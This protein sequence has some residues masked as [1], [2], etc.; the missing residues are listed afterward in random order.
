MS[1]REVKRNGRGQIIS[2]EIIGATDSAVDSQT[3]GEVDLDNDD[4]NG[5]SKALKQTTSPYGIR[6]Q[7]NN[8]RQPNSPDYDQFTDTQFSDEFVNE[9]DITEPRDVFAVFSFAQI[10]ETRS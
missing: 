8:G 5:H 7:F 9:L 3:Y 2:Y 6:T 4:G 10:L 1:K